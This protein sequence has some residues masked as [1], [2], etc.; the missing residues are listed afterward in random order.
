MA[1]HFIYPTHYLDIEIV[2]HARPTY[3]TLHHWI[4]WGVQC[5]PSTMSQATQS[6]SEWETRSED[7]ARQRYSLHW[8]SSGG[9]NLQRTSYT[10]GEP[11]R[12]IVHSTEHP[13]KATPLT[14]H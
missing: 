2:A 11:N 12:A 9:A 1:L 5:K 7:E 10:D 13:S 3:P 6:E 14:T 8:Y 4:H